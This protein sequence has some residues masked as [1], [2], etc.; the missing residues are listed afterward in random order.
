MRT[1]VLIAFLLLGLITFYLGWLMVFQKEIVVYPPE[2]F[3][4]SFSHRWR[5][6]QAAA[7]LKVAYQAR[8]RQKG[9]G[10]LNLITG[11]LCASV[12]VLAI[13]W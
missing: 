8:S 13:L 7:Q 5:S 1:H 12:V 11:A 6:Q 9:I 4:Y 10:W 3:W 2:S